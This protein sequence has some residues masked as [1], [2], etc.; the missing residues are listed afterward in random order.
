MTLCG[1]YLLLCLLKKNI[2]NAT[3]IRNSTTA[4]T[5]PA[6]NSEFAERDVEFEESDVNFL[7]AKITKMDRIIDVVTVGLSLQ[8]MK[9]SGVDFGFF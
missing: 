7:A 9:N 1:I 5:T 3:I 6:I 2:R 4:V 8:T